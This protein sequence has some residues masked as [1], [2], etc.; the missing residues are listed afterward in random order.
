MSS[1]LVDMSVA[2]D[3]WAFFMNFNDQA[4]RWNSDE[5]TEPFP[6]RRLSDVEFIFMYSFNPVSYTHLTL[7][8]KA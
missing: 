5:R 1:A 3:R 4:N 7:P 8:T 2:A 6:I